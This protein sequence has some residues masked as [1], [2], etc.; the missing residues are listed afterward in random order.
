LEDSGACDTIKKGVFEMMNVCR[1]GIAALLVMAATAQCG[2]ESK[3]A[4]RSPVATI[5]I[6]RPSA[7]EGSPTGT[8]KV[9]WRVVRVLKEGADS[10]ATGDE[11]SLPVRSDWAGPVGVNP[12]LLAIIKLSKSPPG[13]KAA[14]LD[15]FLISDD[16]N[17]TVES[18]VSR[19]LRGVEEAGVLAGLGTGTEKAAAFSKMAGETKAPSL[20]LLHE[21]EEIGRLDRDNAE[22]QIAL[23]DGLSIIATRQDAPKCVRLLALEQLYTV[24]VSDK[25]KERSREIQMIT[26]FL[27]VFGSWKTD[28]ADA[29]SYL[30][31][32]LG[33]IEVRSRPTWVKSEAALS[34]PMQRFFENLE[35]YKTKLSAKDDLERLRRVQMLGEELRLRLLQK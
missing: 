5:V 8:S 2:T 34:K 3:A 7:V 20:M 31:R 4:T 9:I 28:S 13:T 33:E 11:F 18:I 19:E 16:P 10:F 17:Q 24:D 1:L 6:A 32:I 27:D 12:D 29:L 15:S 26:R 30:E 25:D 21:A 22:T 23:S 35:S 14:T